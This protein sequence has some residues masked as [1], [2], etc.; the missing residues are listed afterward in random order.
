[1]FE[2]SI[3]GVFIVETPLHCGTGQDIGIV[4]QPLQRERYTNYPRIQGS[5]I[6]G[7]FREHF[8]Q[9][10]YVEEI[11]GPEGGG[12][13]GGEFASA[14]SFAD[15]RVLLFP[16]KSLKDVYVWI[17][18]KDVLERFNRTLKLSGI[19]TYDILTNIPD[20]D[21]DSIIINDNSLV[22]DNKVVLEEYLF[23]PAVEEQLKESFFKLVD[24]IVPNC[25]Q[26]TYF[27]DRLKKKIC[28]VSNEI[29]REFTEM[30]TE[31]INRI[32]INHDTGV[33]K[34]GA[35]WTEEYL[36]TDTILYFPVFATGSRKAGSKLSSEQIISTIKAIQPYIQI[37]GNETVG[38]GFVRINW[39]ENQQ[40]AKNDT[41]NP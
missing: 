37:G 31:V 21:N 1:M 18:C 13:E 23:N 16:V 41:Q 29:F 28:I 27:K 22:I 36:P 14:V 11:F 30:S 17:T 33:V 25:K 10:Q 2:K 15:A 35:L 32:G 40:G 20:C 12:D 4:D 39:I 8:K 6:K 38:K 24:L 5:E 7:V 26:Y 34:E 19:N 9:N 3:I